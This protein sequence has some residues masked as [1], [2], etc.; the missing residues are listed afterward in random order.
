[1]NRSVEIALA[2]A[3][4]AVSPGLSQAAVTITFD[5]VGGDVVATYSG[6]IDLASLTSSNGDSLTAV[7]D[8]DGDAAYFRN[9]GTTGSTTITLGFATFT[10]SPSFVTGAGGARQV[11][12]S[13]T[14]Q[15][16]GLVSGGGFEQI[17]LPSGYVS[18]SSISGTMTFAGTD[19]ATLGLNPGSHLWTWTSGAASDSANFI[20]VP[21]PSVAGLAGLGLSAL[22]RRRRR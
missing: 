14:G 6:S 13:H 7:H 22:L 16:F 20:V 10:A 11:A 2:L 3:A 15:D 5:E 9:Y 19:I 17:I 12:S 8:Y 4:L 21:E 1:M 18:E